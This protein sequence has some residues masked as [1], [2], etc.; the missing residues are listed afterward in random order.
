M[1]LEDYRRPSFWLA[2]IA[3]FFGVMF[4]ILIGCGSTEAFEESKIVRISLAFGLSIAT[5]V[6]TTA[7][8]SGGHL[9]PA[10]SF[11]FLV[12]RKMGILQFF[13][14]I[15]AQL[16]GAIVGAA[17]L[18]GIVPESLAIDTLGTSAPNA[19]VSSGQCFGI[20]LLITFILVWTVLAS[21]DSNRK[22]SGSGALAIGL[23]IAM[24]HLWAVSLIQFEFSCNWC[25][26]VYVVLKR[27]QC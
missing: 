6:W 20:E 9:N 7:H 17:I 22:F 1:G 25:V 10:I 12:S 27:C 23:S 11:A 18:K 16:V 14:Y 19:A 15:I 8:V 21:V 5:L 13:L 24:C 26:F 4:L 3:E 2:P